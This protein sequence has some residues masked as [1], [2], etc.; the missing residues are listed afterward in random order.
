[1]VKLVLLSTSM[2]SDMNFVVCCIL[3]FLTNYFTATVQGGAQ[4][5]R[6]KERQKEERGR[7][8]DGFTSTKNDQHSKF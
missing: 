4:K 6:T 8:R 2:S 5:G 1:M 7:H 3:Q